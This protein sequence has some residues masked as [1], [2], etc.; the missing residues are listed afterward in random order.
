[1]S[2]FLMEGNSLL[3][4]IKQEQGRIIPTRATDPMSLSEE[5]QA[6]IDFVER[7]IGNQ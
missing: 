2:L 6:N 4:W 7:M 1:M 5:E 3:D